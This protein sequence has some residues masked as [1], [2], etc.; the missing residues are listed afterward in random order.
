M[1]YYRV[2]VIAHV[3]VKYYANLRQSKGRRQRRKRVMICLNTYWYWVF[4]VPAWHT[5][6]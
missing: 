5:N 4:C 3:T 2:P 1:A 6:C